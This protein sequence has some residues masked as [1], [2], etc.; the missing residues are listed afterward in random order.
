MVSKRGQVSSVP[1]LSCEDDGK[2]WVWLA[3]EMLLG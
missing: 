2:G 1:E 3:A